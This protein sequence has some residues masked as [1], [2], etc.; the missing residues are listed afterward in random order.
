MGRRLYASLWG[1]KALLLAALA[2]AA[3]T[4]VHDEGSPCLKEI[5]VSHIDLYSTNN[6]TIPIES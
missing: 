2:F 5:A 4:Y 1:G 6:S 3:F